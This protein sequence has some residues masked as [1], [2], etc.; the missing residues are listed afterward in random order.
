MLFVHYLNVT[1]YRNGA[2]GGRIRGSVIC[3][4]T[5]PSSPDTRQGARSLPS[6]SRTANLDLLLGRGRELGRRHPSFTYHPL[7]PIPY[8]IY[9]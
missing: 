1:Y 8:V 3:S 5:A 2:Q 4:G 7:R 6:S 9:K